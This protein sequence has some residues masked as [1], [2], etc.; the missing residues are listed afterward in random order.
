MKKIKLGVTYNLFNGEELLE[1]SI[2]CIRNDVDYINVVWQEYSWTLEK[3]NPKLEKHLNN[4]KNK[5]LIDRVIKFE[6]DVNKS[7]N[8]VRLRRKKGNLGLKDLRINHCT[9]FMM[10]DTD[11]FYRKEEFKKAKKFIV[12]NKITHSACPIYDYRILPC[13][14]MADVRDYSV[15]FIYKFTIFSRVIARQEINNNPCRIDL[16]RTVPYI[17]FINKF[18]YL[19][20]IV[21]HHMTG[22]RLDY[23]N[24]MRN[25]ISKYSEDGRKAIEYYSKLQKDM[26]RMTEQEILSI[27]YIK[28]EDEFNLMQTWKNL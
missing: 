10:M 7:Q 17:P 24:K 4:L 14:R 1:A 27:G 16:F 18:F 5:G 23:D 21:M 28:V 12:E 2:K 9:H 3:A 6:F 13:Y 19:T 26:E 20:D 8:F 25:T 11:E 15:G 22:V